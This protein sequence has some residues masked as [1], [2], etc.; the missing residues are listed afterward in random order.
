MLGSMLVALLTATAS[1]AAPPDVALASA[2]YFRA[3]GVA[4]GLPS[5]TVWKLAQDGAGHLWIGTAD[6]LARYDGV[7]FRVYRHAAGDAGSLSGDD[8]TALYV[9]H[10]NRLWCGGESAGLNLLG[11]DGTFT[12]FRHADADPHSLGGDDVWAIGEDGR[13]AIWVGAYAAGLDRFD[14]STK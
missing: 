4:D 10:R 6:G 1:G 3:I 7:G 12:H 14:E 11:R 2:P 9:D 8:V 13:G 5:S